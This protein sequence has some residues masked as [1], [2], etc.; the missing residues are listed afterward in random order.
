MRLITA[1]LVLAAAAVAAPPDNL[2]SDT[3]I[4]IHVDVAAISKTK[5]LEKI[6]APIHMA[7]ESAG[8]KIED[9]ESVTL[10][11]HGD[12]DDP[13]MYASV[14]GKFDAEKIETFLKG[15][16]EYT[17]EKRDGMTVL[18]P[19]SADVDEA[20]EVA[21]VEGGILVGSARGSLEK[22][23]A[24]RKP[25]AA[26]SDVSKLLRS[27][28]EAQF[29]CAVLGTDAVRKSMREDPD[30]EMFAGV[31]SIVLTANVHEKVELSYDFRGEGGAVESLKGTA[32]F[33]PDAVAK[34]FL[35]ELGV[36]DESEGTEEGCGEPC[37]CG[38]PFGED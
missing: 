23:L 17:V 6:A 15:I 11:L 22:L 4:A 2:P 21:I 5:L 26:E 19:K 28:G 14:R 34:M 35:E 13:D 38:E 18:L 1:V 10:G 29:S 36:D 7:C 24:A 8:L 33:A 25:D 37:G 9:I 27:A 32:T 20:P 3:C 12:L 31:K 16:S 30:M